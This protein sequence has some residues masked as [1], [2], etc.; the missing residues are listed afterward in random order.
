ME[1]TESAV[2]EAVSYTHLQEMTLQLQQVAQ[3][4]FSVKLDVYKR[5]LLI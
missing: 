1:K 3:Q 5:Q 4:N 2:H